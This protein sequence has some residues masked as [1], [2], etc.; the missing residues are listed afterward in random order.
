MSD[1]LAPCGW[2]NTLK[3]IAKPLPKSRAMIADAIEEAIF[4]AFGM[5]PPGGNT[6]PI[7]NAAHSKCPKCGPYGEDWCV[8][9]PNSKSDSEGKYNIR[10]N[11]MPI[12]TALEA[13]EIK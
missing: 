4:G 13:K 7:A 2:P 8:D 9:C 10:G 5:E 11:Q 6:R 3:T 12:G 1:D